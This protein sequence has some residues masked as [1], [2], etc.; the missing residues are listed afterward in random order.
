VLRDAL[1]SAL[2]DSLMVRESEIAQFA[3]AS[4]E[5]LVC[6]FRWDALSPQKGFGQDGCQLALNGRACLHEPVTGPFSAG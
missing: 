6:A 2:A 1:G 3:E 4:A 5:D